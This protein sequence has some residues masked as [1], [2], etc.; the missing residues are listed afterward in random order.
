MIFSCLQLVTVVLVTLLNSFEY[1]CK[2][3]RQNHNDMSSMPYAMHFA[4]HERQRQSGQGGAGCPPAQQH[5]APTKSQSD[6]QPAYNS[7]MMTSIWGMYNKY[8]PHNL[9]SKNEAPAESCGLSDY[10]SRH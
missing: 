8:S 2:I 9:K 6:A 5:P 1:L 4:K 7:K 10:M 3:L